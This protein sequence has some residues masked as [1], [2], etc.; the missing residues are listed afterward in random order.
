MVAELSWIDVKRLAYSIF[1]D[2]ARCEEIYLVTRLSQ[3]IRKGPVK[4]KNTYVVSQNSFREIINTM[5]QANDI[6][7]RSK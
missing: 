3:W 7:K 2:D 6:L 5:K 1:P 4:R